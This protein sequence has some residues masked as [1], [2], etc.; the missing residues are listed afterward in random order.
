L[1]NNK[2]KWVIKIPSQPRENIWNH[3][4]D[5]FRELAYLYKDNNSDVDIQV[6]D[7][8]NHCWLYPNILFMIDQIMNGLMKN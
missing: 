2:Q 3:A 6:V 1:E 5:S 4:N 7:N 8:T